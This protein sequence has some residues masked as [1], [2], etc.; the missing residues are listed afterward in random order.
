MAYYPNTTIPNS[1]YARGVAVA[2]NLAFVDIFMNRDPTEYDIQYQI[3]QKWLNTTDNTLWVLKNFSSIGGSI[4][5]DWIEIGGLMK[6]IAELTGNTGGPVGPAPITG[7]VNILGDG[8]TVTV[9]GNPATN[10]LTISSGPTVATT[11]TEDAGT[12]IPATGNLNILGGTGINTAGSGDTVTINGNI[13]KAA[14]SSS[15]T[16]DGVASFNSTQFSVDVNGFVSADGEIATTYTGNSGTAVP[17]AGVLHIV[18]GGGVTTTG[19]G[20]TITISSL[21]FTSINNQVFAASG[22]YTPT[23]GML[24]CNVQI[25]GGGGSGSGNGATGA[26]QVS[27]GA[28]GS[29]GEYAAGIFSA[30]TI[31]ASQVVTIGAGGIGAMAASGNPGGTSSVG[32]LITAVGGNGGNYSGV[33]SFYSSIGTAGG[34]GGTGGDYRAQGAPG[35]QGF[36]SFSATIISGGMGG[37][38]QLGGGGPS[39]NSSAG[40]NGGGYGSGGSAASAY[41]ASAARPGGNGANGVVVITEYIG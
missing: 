7:N 16:N 28:G 9:A 34:T 1:L 40:N 3:Q 15:L 12:A 21:G 11:Y 30:A 22:T 19:A 37:S 18:G 38:T 25:F 13:A 4:T 32:A 10:T 35:N 33:G 23:A 39:S 24:Y 5:A 2:N 31:G 29:A 8:T 26:A 6:Y 20:S 17:A 27:G 36:G 14:A 41:G